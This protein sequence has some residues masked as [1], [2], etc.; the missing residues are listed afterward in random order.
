LAEGSVAKKRALLQ[1]L[2]F[3]EKWLQKMAENRDLEKS[4]KPVFLFF[5][6]SPQTAL[7]A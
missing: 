1:K 4:K 7:S 5:Q 3:D 6:Q 2:V